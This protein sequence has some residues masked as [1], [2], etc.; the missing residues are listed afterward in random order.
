M[1]ENYTRDY[2]LRE[3]LNKSPIGIREC[4]KDTHNLRYMVELNR[5]FDKCVLKCKHCGAIHRRMWAESGKIGA[6]F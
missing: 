5:D 2:Q 4:C 6:K 3:R 1:S